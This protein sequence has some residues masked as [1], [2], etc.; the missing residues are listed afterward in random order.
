M[1]H[2]IERARR[3]CVSSLGAGLEVQRLTT[4]F[5]DLDTG[6]RRGRPRRSSG[7]RRVTGSGRVQQRRGSLVAVPYDFVT[8]LTVERVA[9]YDQAAQTAAGVRQP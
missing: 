4:G 8:R 5:A 7:S 3:P 2:S 1:D 9:L 6:Q